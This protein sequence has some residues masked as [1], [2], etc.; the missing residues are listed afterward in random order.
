MS[1][2][3]TLTPV[4]STITSNI[5]DDNTVFNIVNGN[6]TDTLTYADIKEWGISLS[7]LVYDDQH[8]ELFV[9]T[10]ILSY[11]NESNPPVWI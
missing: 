11:I 1:Q 9:A 6:F 3:L 10:I 2:A 4:D 8:P 7:T 5:I